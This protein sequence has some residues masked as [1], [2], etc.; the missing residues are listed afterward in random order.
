[1]RMTTFIGGLLYSLL[2]GMGLMPAQWTERPQSSTNRGWD[3]PPDVL[4]DTQAQLRR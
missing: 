4:R 1:M 2:W 3:A